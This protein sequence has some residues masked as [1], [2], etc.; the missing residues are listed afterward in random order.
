M[1]IKFSKTV[2]VPWLHQTC[3]L[4]QVL[5]DLCVFSK[6]L[7]PGAA[8]QTLRNGDNH[9]FL[10]FL[11][12]FNVKFITHCSSRDLHSSHTEKSREGNKKQKWSLSHVFLWHSIGE[13]DKWVNNNT[14]A[15]NISGNVQRPPLQR[16]N[17]NHLKAHESW[18]RSDAD[19]P[20]ELD[21]GII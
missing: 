13:D 10:S 3:K 4:L 6:Y 17:W 9:K 8:A 19:L 18:S 2:T 11:S 1:T 20:S 16:L 21:K 5:C 15:C 12:L 14:L 7:S